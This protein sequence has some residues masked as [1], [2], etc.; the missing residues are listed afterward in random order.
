MKKKNN[1]KQTKETKRLLT[2]ILHRCR[3]NRLL[4]YEHH[5]NNSGDFENTSYHDR[6]IELV[7]L[8]GLKKLSYKKYAKEKKTIILKIVSNTVSSEKFSK[9]S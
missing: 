3:Y 6:I 9:E 1:N 5:S 2:E 8:N 4:S 7:Q